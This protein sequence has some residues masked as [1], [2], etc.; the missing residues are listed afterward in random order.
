[1]GINRSTGDDALHCRRQRFVSSLHQRERVKRKKK[2][3]GI[4]KE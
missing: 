2:K 1:M 4:V 3:E